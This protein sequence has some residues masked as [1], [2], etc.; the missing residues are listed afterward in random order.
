MREALLIYNPVAGTLA[1][2]DPDL[3]PRLCAH[4]EA[5]GIKPELVPTSLERPAREIAEEAAR[6]GRELV[7]VAGGDGTVSD[8]AKG[9]VGSETTLG[10]VPLGTF[11]NLARSMGISF[12]PETACDQVV[13]GIP[14]KI[15]VGRV[16]GK[17]YFFEVAGIGLDAA[18]FPLAEDIKGGAWVRYFE[19]AGI[20]S[21]FS[22]FK[23]SITLDHE[24]PRKRWIK[25]RHKF[26]VLA[27]MILCAN[28]P[29]YGPGCEISPS[30]SLEDRLLTVHL[31]RNVSRLGIFFNLIRRIGG[32][33]SVKR[34]SDQFT[35]RR[36]DIKGGRPQPIHVDGNV[37]NEWPLTIESIPGALK[38]LKGK[39]G[40]EEV[41]KEAAAMTLSD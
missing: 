13:R 21:R 6:A 16:N 4:L 34:V 7:I 37:V 41:I 28:A 1:K 38:V 29:F 5:G 40:R 23:V 39:P 10:I 19:A 25:H 2:A 3:L 12:D 30:S 31:F 20:F 26:R 9:L 27:W 33:K 35:A 18:L 11:N 32:A 17:H 36:I 22:P 24:H 14:T 15:D 8:A